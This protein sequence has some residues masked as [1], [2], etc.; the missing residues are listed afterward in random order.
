[1]GSIDIC[2]SL[3]LITI[4]VV[5]LNVLTV[6]ANPDVIVVPDEYFSIQEAINHSKSGD[7]IFVKSGIYFENLVIDK[8][9]LRLVGEDKDT[10]IIDGCGTGIVT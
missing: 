4:L 6:E 1:M 8:N 10:T 9:G 2:Y 5:A 7:T 3:F